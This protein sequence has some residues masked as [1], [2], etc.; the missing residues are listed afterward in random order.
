V[1]I[2][3]CI[4]VKSGFVHHGFRGVQHFSVHAETLVCSAEEVVLRLAFAEVGVSLV[5]LSDT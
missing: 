3:L 2:L 1:P 4:G 5:L